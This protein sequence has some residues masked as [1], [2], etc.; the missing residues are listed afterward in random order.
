MTPRIEN[1]KGMKLLGIKMQMSLENN[2]TGNLW[3]TFMQRRKE[4]ENVFTSDMISM[5]IYPADYFVE[6]STSKEFDKW[7]TV[8]VGDFENIPNGFDKYLL[9][10]GLYA[11]FDYKGLS[12]DTSIFNYIYETW[13]P[14]SIYNLDNRPHVEILGEKYKNNDPSSEEEI[15][16]PIKLKNT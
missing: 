10:A 14:N 1:L 13:L 4:I 12:T 2:L 11:I 5:Q 16:I 15:C 6:F 7:A 3:R 8:E 9:P